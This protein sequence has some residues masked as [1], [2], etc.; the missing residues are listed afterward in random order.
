MNQSLIAIGVVMLIVGFVALSYVQTATESHFFGWFETS[1]T[2]KPYHYLGT[3]L[4]IGGIILVIV[5][6][7]VGKEK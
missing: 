4:M 7:L 6:A 3:P 5:G 2:S 1:E